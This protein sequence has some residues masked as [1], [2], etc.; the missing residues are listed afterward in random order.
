M[1]RDR[2]IRNGVASAHGDGIDDFADDA[3]VVV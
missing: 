3:V 1:S 2:V